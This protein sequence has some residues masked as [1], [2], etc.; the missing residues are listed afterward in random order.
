MHF[1]EELLGY[2][3]EQALIHRDNMVLRRD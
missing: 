1:I 3:A 2:M